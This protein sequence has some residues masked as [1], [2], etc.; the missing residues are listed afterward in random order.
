[1]KPENQSENKTTAAS[2]TLTSTTQQGNFF[3]LDT[4]KQALAFISAFNYSE[5]EPVQFQ[6]LDD[7]TKDQSKTKSL[8][9]TAANM[10]DI[11]EKLHRCNLE[12]LNIYFSLNGSKAQYIQ[13]DINNLE[14]V[15]AFSLKPSL[16]VQAG[17]MLFVY[18]VVVNDSF[19]TWQDIQARLLYKFDTVGEIIKKDYLLP[20][21]G[22]NFSGEAVR[23]LTVT[24]N[25]YTQSQF[26]ELLPDIRAEIEKDKARAK[27][28]SLTDNQ[29]DKNN[30]FIDDFLITIQT[31]AYKPYT[32]ALSFFDDLLEGGVIRQSL[33]QVLAAPSTGK[34]T[35]CQQ[36]AEEMASHDKKVLYFNFEMS[37]EQMLAKAISYRLAKKNDGEK[38]IISAT[39]ILQGYN[40]ND[41]QRE[42]I[43]EEL[44][45]Y[46][47]TAAQYITYKN[48]TADLESIKLLLEEIGE[49]ASQRGQAAPV[50][51]VDYLHLITGAGSDTQEILKNAV[52]CFKD[53]AINYNSIVFL[54]VAANRDSIKKGQIT[55]TSGRDS[56]AIEYAGDYVLS[57]NYE[58]IDNGNID[59]NN[60][61]EF[62]KIK[63][64]NWR[65][66]ILRVLKHR[67]GVPGTSCLLWYRPAAN[68]F[69]KSVGEFLPLDGTKERNEI[70][71][72]A[73]E[74]AAKKNKSTDQTDKNKLFEQDDTPPASFLE[75]K[76]A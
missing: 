25:I 45:N 68:I 49:R 66:M 28:Q 30:N 36:I 37:K 8:Q 71:K 15:Q 50:V 46:K 48:E 73:E 34:T 62:A 43:T 42:R 17:N 52:K 74:R 53:Y 10:P 41:S 9:A 33:V 65:K 29:A 21:P 58:E 18:W 12:Q 47:K 69:Y 32:T 5:A 59:A 38:P 3:A 16:I 26:A 19:N 23:L 51:F 6:A 2:A 35:L 7:I 40:W 44:N 13:T 55:L 67:L 22:F 70:E 57:L 31:E 54:I 76:K 27:A 56:S 20:V 1:M 75:P 60:E 64:K 63:A 14:E 11:M 24:N 39:D 72:E 4:C 61:A